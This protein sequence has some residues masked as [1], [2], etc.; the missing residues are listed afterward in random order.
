M[1]FT[2]WLHHW[3]MSVVAEGVRVHVCVL[4]HILRVCAVPGRGIPKK[5]LLAV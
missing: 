1:N 5:N 3:A 2:D 4:N